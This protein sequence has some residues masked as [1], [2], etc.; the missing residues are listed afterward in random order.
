MPSKLVPILEQN[1]VILMYG[2]LESEEVC[3]FS[4][5]QLVGKNIRLE[6]FFLFGW[7]GTAG[8]F[9]IIGAISASKKLAKDVKVNKCFGLHQIQEALDCYSENMTAGKVFLSPSITE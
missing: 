1:S 8:M 7:M 3:S 9:K 6:P 2:F 5:L 4:A